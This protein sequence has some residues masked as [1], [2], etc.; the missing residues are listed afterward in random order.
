MEQRGTHRVRTRDLEHLL[1]QG[2]DVPVYGP[3]LR[4]SCRRMETA[5]WLRT[6]RAPNLQLAVELTETGRELAVPLLI[7]EQDRCEAKRR[8]SEVRV[9]PLRRAHPTQLAKETPIDIPVELDGNRHSA[10]RG[11]YIIRLDGSTCL[12]LWNSEG[13]VRHIEGD[14]LQVATWLQ[15]CHDAGL[16]VR[17]QINE[18]HTQA[19]ITPFSVDHI[20]E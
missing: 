12:Q 20:Q 11:V 18:S 9:L 17:I 8:T 14:P 2:G 3:N 15:D 6:L 7:D 1:T 4:A 19:D 16:D 13:Q 10:W 5:G